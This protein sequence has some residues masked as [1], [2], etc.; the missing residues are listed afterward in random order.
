MNSAGRS[1]DWPQWLG[2]R[3]DGVWRETGILRKFPTNGPAVRWRTGIGS[4]YTG[5]AVTG[6]R[7]FVCD[8][9]SPASVPQQ[10][11]AGKTTTPGQERVV[12]LDEADGKIVW[13]QAYDCEYF[14]GFP[15]GP[16][17]TP[18]VSD[19][20]VYT[21]GAMGN[22]LCLES[23]TGKL[24]WSHDFKKEYGAKTPMWGFASHPLVDGKKVICLA[25]GE[26]SVAVAFDKETGKELWRA[27]SS[28]ELG[29]NPPM[30]YEA[31]G[32]RQLIVWHPEALNSLDPE[33]GKVY[34]TQPFASRQGLTIPTPRKLGDLLFVTTFYSGPMMMRLAADQ[35]TAEILWR[36]KSDNEQKT[37]GLHGLMCT[38]FLEDGYIYGV[39]SY[40][41]LRC[42]KADT[43]ERLWETFAATDEKPIRWANAFLVKN[44][45]VFFIPNEQGDLII[46]RLSPKGYEE[47]SRTHLLE[48]DNHNC[49][50]W[51]VW[52]HPAFANRCCYARNDKE[53]ICVS[54]AAEK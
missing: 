53:I 35:P 4:G 37:D 13:Q 6:G 42:L 10:A 29:Y 19:G 1:D 40:G 45:D 38:P 27:L 26:G 51:V 52:S 34:W 44:Q 2:P 47:L 41:Q 32:H 39:C 31:G 12:C 46:A 3:R 50:R 15:A 48:P 5:A 36:G 30:I 23:A 54:L 20:K 17:A 16:R 8:R 7:V 24:V 33:T 49:G 11:N 14:L 21:L 18:T 43:G 28:R 22:L 9:L 25:G